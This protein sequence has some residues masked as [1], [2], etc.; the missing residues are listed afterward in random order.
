MKHDPKMSNEHA[1]QQPNHASLARRVRVALGLEPGDLL[2]TG[3]RVVNVFTRRTEDADLIVVDGRIAG[4]GRFEWEASRTIRLDGR[5]VIPGLIDS[6]MHVESTLLTPAELSRLV[7][8]RGTTAVISDSHEIGNVLGVT[9][10][11]D[12]AA[13]SEGLPL[14]LFFMAS[15]CV[16]AT[17]WEDAGA[18]IGPVQVRELLGRPHV[19]GLAEMMDVPAVLGAD[20]EVLA[21]IGAARSLGMAIDGHA[22]GLD[23][24][25][26]M[27]YAST[28]VRS[29][30]ES[31]TAAE[32]RAKAA[33][34]MLVQVRE[35]SPAQNLDALLPLLASGEIDESWCLV[36]D[37]IFPDDLRRHGHIDGLLRRVVAGGVRPEVAV[38]HAS[39]V[40][41]RHYGLS[42][43]GAVA[44]GYR[45]DLVVVDDLEGF[46]VNLVIKDGRVVAREGRYLAEH[47]P[48]RI[49]SANTIRIAPVDEGAFR[50]RPS[51]AT[52]AVIG[53]VP[54]QIVTR[55][56]TRTVKVADG[57][58]A[59]DPEVDVALIASIERHRASGRVGLGLVS[60]LGLTRHGALGSSVAHDSHNLIVA[61]TNPGDMVACVRALAEAGGGFVAASGGE[62]RALLPLP[63]AGL[64]SL[65]DVDTVCDQL[66]AVHSAARGLG[67]P[68]DAPFGTLSFLALPV[69]PELRIT[70]Q[71]VFHVG[72]Q[73]FLV[74]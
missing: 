27:A 28:G 30:H 2:L 36:T 38:R 65:A 58:W 57:E 71:G 51:S 42:D 66:D 21:K 17:S 22:P 7:V 50:L 26:L 1:G 19:L 62:A 74:L 69:I 3:G 73:R 25:S 8:P 32:A 11:D 24:R 33:L 18:T 54:D 70:A 61:G 41:A 56:E 16:P 29:D 34:G 44:P 68:L 9:G 13:A 6:H 14:D 5:T 20:P 43:R 48:S 40:P 63:V 23:P 4:V 55:L 72:E 12:L 37:D 60:G 39:L 35:G 45:A 10:I 46:D 64:L 31:T 52:C 49:G 67:C 59:F 15:S 53:I 47:L